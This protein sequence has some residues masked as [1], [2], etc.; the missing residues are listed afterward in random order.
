MKKL[1]LIV[2]LMSLTIR[3]IAPNQKS[4]LITEPPPIEPFKKLIYAVGMVEGMGDT[5]AYNERE[6]AAGYFQIRPIRLED[7]NNRTGNKY[8]MNDMFD[9]NISEKV[10]LYFASQIGPYDLERIAKNWNGS[11]AKTIEY[12]ERIKEYL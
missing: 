11:G 12:W 6:M 3:A 10:F 7:Y 4:L 1:F 5:T 8:T 2:F 9:Y